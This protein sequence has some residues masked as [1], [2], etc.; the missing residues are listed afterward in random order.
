MA[1]VQ[2]GGWCTLW[3]E[4]RIL[5]PHYHPS[6]LAFPFLL[7]IVALGFASASPVSQ[8]LYYKRDGSGVNISSLPPS[9]DPFYVLP[10]N[11]DSY[12]EGAIIRSR[13]IPTNVGFGDSAGSAYQLFYRTNGVNLLPDATVT[14]VVAPKSPASGVPKV[15]AIATP[16]DSAAFD[17]SVSWSVYPSECASRY[18]TK[19][20]G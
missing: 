14:T 10:D 18:T 2:K 5:S 3:L 13:P 17:C 19:I 1:G 20:W 8:L 15:V 6:M 4:Q 12:E 16:E 9:Q 11:L 7:A